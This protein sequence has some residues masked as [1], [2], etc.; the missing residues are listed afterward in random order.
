[1]THSAQFLKE[2]ITLEDT[3][4]KKND[5]WIPLRPKTTVPYCPR[6]ASSQMARA[7]SHIVVFTLVV[8]CF[9]LKPASSKMA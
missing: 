8:I 4:P 2:R 5:F 1:V 6:L 3:F 9:L 7:V